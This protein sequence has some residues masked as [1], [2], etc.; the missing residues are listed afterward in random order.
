MKQA[1]KCWLINADPMGAVDAPKATQRTT[2]MALAA[3]EVSRLFDG[4][5]AWRG[6]RLYPILVL[7]VSTWMRQGDILGL[8]WEDLEGDILTVRRTFYRD[9]KTAEKGSARYGP[10]KGGK[11]RR[12]EIDARVVSVLKE[13]RK[14]LLEERTSAPS[15]ESEHVFTT[16]EG[17]PIHRAVLLQ[18]FRRLCKREGLPQLTFHELR[19]TCATLVAKRNVHLTAVQRMLGHADIKTTLGTYSHEWPGAAKDASSAL[20]DVLF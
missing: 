6:G 17:K 3:D 11:T 10:P 1:L 18:S 14:K 7:A 8:L 5:K 12:V 13:H 9:T 2:R 20:A 16:P 19:H 4:A 15:W